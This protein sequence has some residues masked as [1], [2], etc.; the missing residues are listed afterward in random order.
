MAELGLFIS[1]ICLALYNLLNGFV[2]ITLYGKQP[3]IIV[4]TLQVRELSLKEFN[5]FPK[6]T[7]L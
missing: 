5:D 7:Q 4:R 6:A 2:S 3:C 1:N